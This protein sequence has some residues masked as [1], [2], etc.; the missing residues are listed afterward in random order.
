[1]PSTSPAQARLMAMVAHNPAMAKKTG[2]PVKVARDFNQADKGGK[3]LRAKHP[4]VRQSLDGARAE[5]KAKHG[6]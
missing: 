3:M 6:H 5:V 4:T 1:M 2:V